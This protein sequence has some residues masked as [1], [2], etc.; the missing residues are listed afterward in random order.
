MEASTWTIVSI[1][2]YSL[3]GLLFIFAIIMFFKLNIPAIIGD[4]TGKTAAR[5]IREIREQNANTGKKSF[6][7]DPFNL[8]RGLLTEPVKSR[9]RGLARISARLSG[10]LSGEMNGRTFGRGSGSEG[11]IFGAGGQTVGNDGQAVAQIGGSGSQ[12]AGQT[13]GRTAVPLPFGSRGDT[14]GDARAVV[15]ESLPTEVLADQEPVLYGHE[16]TMVLSAATDGTFSGQAGRVDKLSGTETPGAGTVVLFAEA[17]ELPSLSETEDLFREAVTTSGETGIRLEK[18]EG[19]IPDK[20]PITPD[21][22]T[23]IS[24]KVTISPDKDTIFTDTDINFT[25]KP[26]ASSNVETITGETEVLACET[27]VLSPDTEVLLSETEIL[28]P[29]LKPSSRETENLI[30]ETEPL[31]SETEILSIDREPGFTGTEVLSSGTEL[32]SPNL[33]DDNESGA[34]TVLGEAPGEENNIS[35]VPLDFKIV[36]NVV[37]T[38]TNETL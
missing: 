3:A 1:V 17:E 24:D 9:S 36:K 10:R 16:G 5:Q 20:V 8:E 30:P 7:P 29:E 31:S 32:L 15:A 37:I 33:E 34:T 35:V 12:R 4:L 11:Q 26:S 28:T 19:P 13:V 38:H 23:I 18:G 27:E 25:D 21:I 6:H 22:A 14:V 2:S